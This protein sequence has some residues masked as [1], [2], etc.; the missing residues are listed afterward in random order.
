MST[1]PAYSILCCKC[2]IPILPNCLNMCPRCT[3]T[4]KQNE[5]STIKTRQ[6]V[7]SCRKCARY[8]LPPRKWISV[9]NEN[10][11]L[12]YLIVRHGGLRS[13]RIVKCEFGKVEEHA[14]RIVLNLEID[15]T[16]CDN[17]S[18]N[19]NDISVSDNNN[20]CD[21]NVSVSN[22]NND[23]SHTNNNNDISHANNNNSITT[24]AN[25]VT[26]TNDAN[27]IANTLKTTITFKIANKQCPDCDKIA[28][29]QYWTSIVQ[30]R[31]KSKSQ[32][33]ML[34]L[35]QCILKRKL[36]STCTNIKERKTGIDFYYLD[37]NSA[38]R[39]ASFVKSV[40]G[41]NMHTSSRLMTEDRNNNRMKYKF[42]YSMEIFPLSRDDLVVL[43]EAY[44]KRRGVGRVVV[45]R[46]V[47]TS[48]ALEDPVSGVVVEVSNGGFWKNR[49]CFRTVFSSS[50]LCV[51]RVGEIERDYATCSTST[52]SKSS[53]S[54][55]SSVNNASKGNGSKGNGSKGSGNNASNG[56][57]GNTATNTNTPTNT[58]TTTTT[59][60]TINTTTTT[61]T[62][63]NT[64][65]NTTTN[66]TTN[67]NNNAARV[68]DC[69]VTKGNDS[70]QCKTALPIQEDDEVYGYD[71]GN[72]NLHFI[73]RDYFKVILV[74]KKYDRDLVNKY[75]LV[76]KKEMDREYQFFL[77]D[78]VGDNELR[79]DVDLFDKTG[80][81]VSGLENMSI[82]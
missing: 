40:I 38:L 50:D 25:N 27:I 23:I 15:R 68:V 31:Q 82:N 61:N 6:T 60:T 16:S 71:L 55:K 70:F 10:D 22:N 54:S 36:Y 65:I 19:N 5:P 4:E 1:Q 21:S 7:E 34:Y 64:T 52:S 26:T 39:F 28:A 78:V 42:S 49:E 9:E 67:T 14:K 2:A 48:L 59:N 8:Y 45:V 46:R 69:F 18:D 53:K 75:S 12:A 57:S 73:D 62:T 72:S 81:V 32:R 66:T 3:A 56:S 24:T 58:N 47:R 37:R 43:E 63:T 44:A 29:K 13:S 80:K 17:V 33:T 35:E 30:L 79:R 76:T 74:R 77:E 41:T 20:E 11:M 51:F